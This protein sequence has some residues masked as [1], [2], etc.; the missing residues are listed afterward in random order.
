MVIRSLRTV[1]KN[2]ARSLR[3]GLRKLSGPTDDSKR[4]APNRGIGRLPLCPDRAS[5][6]NDRGEHFNNRFLSHFLMMTGLNPFLAEP[7]LANMLWLRACSL[8]HLLDALNRLRWKISCFFS[9]F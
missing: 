4:L 2:K 9:A 6:H 3:T 8:L 7:L 5:F 1:P